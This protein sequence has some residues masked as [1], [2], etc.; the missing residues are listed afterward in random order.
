ML[1]SASL[2][3]LE[4]SS[5]LCPSEGSPRTRL[6]LAQRCNGGAIRLIPDSLVRRAARRFAAS[7][8]PAPWRCFLK[9]FLVPLQG[10]GLAGQA[11]TSGQ[12]S[13]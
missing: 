7:E 1:V 8:G 5:R 9:A 10:L 11:V 13:L 2:H 12:V 4:V 3:L 6:A